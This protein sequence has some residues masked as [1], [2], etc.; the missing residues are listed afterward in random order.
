MCCCGFRSQADHSQLWSHSLRLEETARAASG[1][2]RIFQLYVRG[3][4]AFVDDYV[5]RARSTRVMRRSAITVD[6]AIYSRRERDHHRALRQALAG[7]RAEGAAYP[8]RALL[9]PRQAFKDK[10]AVPLI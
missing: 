9:G 1:A 5:R 8:G 2:P 7:R 10:H 3:D 4:D 6:V